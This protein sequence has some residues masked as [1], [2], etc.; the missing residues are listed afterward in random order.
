MPLIFTTEIDTLDNAGAISLHADLDT[1]L[2]ELRTSYNDVASKWG[3][4]IADKIFTVNYEGSDYLLQTLI[5]NVKSAG[6][7]L[8]GRAVSAEEDV[9][10]AQDR[11]PHE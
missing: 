8:R 10:C 4:T 9:H 3:Y 2:G 1:K 5:D 7:G 11:E 6:S